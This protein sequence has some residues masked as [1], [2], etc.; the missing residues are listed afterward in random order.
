MGQEVFKPHP[1]YKGYTVGNKGTVN[2][3][4]KDNIGYTKPDGYR[5]AYLKDIGWRYVHRLVYETFVGAIPEGMEI[6]H[7]DGDKL[8]NTA[9]NLEAMTHQ[10]NIE[11]SYK[12]LKRK[13]ISGKDHWN[14]GK[15]L[16]ADTRAK[17]AAAKM[18]TKHPKFTGWWVV[19]G[20][21]Y[22]S[23]R[24]ASENTGISQDTIRRRCKKGERGFSFEEYYF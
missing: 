1:V 22:T 11:H 18:G 20:V 23:A 13:I 15:K 17:M 12:T 14:F 2:G 6:N 10:K 8:N 3:L 4:R 9:D 16:P 7:K 5:Y 21:K 24:E 19:D